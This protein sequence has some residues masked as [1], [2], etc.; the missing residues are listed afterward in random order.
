MILIRQRSTWEKGERSLEPLDA[1]HVPLVFLNGSFFTP[2]AE[3]IHDVRFHTGLMPARLELTAGEWHRIQTSRCFQ[4]TVKYCGPN[5]TPP[6][7]ATPEM[8]AAMLGIE[9]RVDGVAVL[10]PQPPPPAMNCRNCGAPPKLNA[11]ACVHC[12]TAWTDS[13]TPTREPSL[14][15]LPHG[16]YRVGG[17]G[18]LHTPTPGQKVTR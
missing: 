17:A 8:L 3:A 14:K 16:D 7:L 1:V 2:L 15:D 6:G 10:K 11:K 12:G 4:D 18:L 9:V 13:G 5:D